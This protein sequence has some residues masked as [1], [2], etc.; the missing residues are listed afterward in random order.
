[1]TY[2]ASKQRTLLLLASL[3]LEISEY[4]SSVV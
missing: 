3:I 1:M 2:L 4:V